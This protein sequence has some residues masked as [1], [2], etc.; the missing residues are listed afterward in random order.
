MRTLEPYINNMVMFDI[1]YLEKKAQK[2]IKKL[3]NSRDD[4]N[5]IQVEMMR[6]SMKK[7]ESKMYSNNELS[8]NAIAGI[9][10]FVILL[11]QYIK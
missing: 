1:S 2:D 7:M 9:I 10:S 11:F 3:I 4:N 6:S 5:E 8:R